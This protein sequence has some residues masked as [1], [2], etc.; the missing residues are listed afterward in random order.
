MIGGKKSVN[1][2]LTNKGISIVEILVAGFIITYITLAV[3]KSVT[4]LFKQYKSVAQFGSVSQSFHDISNIINFTGCSSFKGES[5]TN[6]KLEV[7]A[8]KNGDIVVFKKLT[9]DAT[10]ADRAKYGLGNETYISKITLKKNFSGAAKTG[11]AE[12][13]LG[14]NKFTDEVPPLPASLQPSFNR[15]LEGIYISLNDDGTFKTC[16]SETCPERPVTNGFPVPKSAGSPTDCHDIKFDVPIT[17]SGQSY[18]KFKNCKGAVPPGSPSGTERP[19]TGMCIGV[20]HCFKGYW[21]YSARCFNHEPT[22]TGGT[23]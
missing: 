17:L 7:D 19:V 18:R 12:L 21:S 15:T 22:P 10:E 23:P 6:N 20:F 2:L 13:I 8:I 16:A 11:S 4:Y 5:F 3:V 14:Y 9:K 1:I